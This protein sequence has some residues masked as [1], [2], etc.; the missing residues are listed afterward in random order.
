MPIRNQETANT[1]GSKAINDTRDRSQTDPL[2]T[3]LQ[4]LRQWHVVH[5]TDRPYAHAHISTVKKLVSFS[6]GLAHMR[7]L[8]LQLFKKT[9]EWTFQCPNILP[10]WDP[11][12][13]TNLNTSIICKITMTT[14]H[15]MIAEYKSEMSQASTV[16][17]GGFWP[18]M[19]LG[20]KRTLALETEY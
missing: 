15:T 4:P 7:K 10:S 6:K 18:A 5:P 8:K 20:T 16:G 1:V 17:I 12:P 19:T 9:N 11:H 3:L 13:S 14:E 2:A